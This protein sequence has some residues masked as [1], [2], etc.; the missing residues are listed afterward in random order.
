MPIRPEDQPWYRQ[1]HEALERVIAAQMARDATKP[2]TPEREVAE[3]ECDA[4]L[5]ALANDVIVLGGGISNINSLY[6]ELP[7]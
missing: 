2:G 3:R 7:N 5:A 6:D 4:S 1:W